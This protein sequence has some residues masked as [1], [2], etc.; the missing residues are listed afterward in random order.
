MS[1]LKEDV[2]RAVITI[3]K[4]QQ[5]EWIALKEIYK[6]VEK[7][8]NKPNANNGASI[9]ASLETH[10]SLSEAFSG[11]EMYVLK[12]KGLGLYKSVNYDGLV[13][14]NNL[15][16]G[17]IFTREEIMKMFKVS[18]QRGI[19]PTNTY[20]AIVL[21]TSESNGIYDDSSVVD[22][23]IIYTGEGLTGDQTLSFGN[24]SIYNSLTND[25]P[26]YL[27][28]KD[29]NRKYTFEGKVYLCGN[30][31]Q[32][33]E[34]D[35]LGNV[36]KVWKFPL[37]VIYDEHKLIEED[38]QFL[39]LLSELENLEEKIIIEVSNNEIRVVDETLKIR[40]YREAIER[41]KAN[42]S[43][44]PDYIAEEI[45]KD[46]QGKINEKL[47][48]EYELKKLISAEAEA[49]VAKMQEFFKNKKENEGF[50]IL[51]FEIDAS[52][53]YIEKYIEV[54]STKSYECTPIDITENEIA[55]AKEH[56]DQYYLYRV[57][58]SESKERYLKI[59][60]GRDLLSDYKFVPTTYKIYSN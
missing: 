31:Y 28:T 10:C 13:E 59:V 23:K 8:R 35:T 20:R 19:M 42:R 34:K 1:T 40:K 12:E 38:V 17:D 11:N 41:K 60:N 25:I 49:E 29:N 24:K 32:I 2:N 56:I 37:Q 26:M 36:R 30:P 50:D 39:E 7:I 55:F 3:H 18:G 22:G 52:G 54:K 33:D 27:F 51:S 46:K 43:S 48:Y 58:L 44:R 21:T 45:I 5:K 53:K 57:V 6:A 47:V 9:R 15:E 16:I 4:E 14:I